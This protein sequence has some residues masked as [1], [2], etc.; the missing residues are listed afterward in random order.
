[1]A[2][3]KKIK[4]FS[5]GVYD[6][7]ITNLSDDITRF[8][9]ECSIKIQGIYAQQTIDLKIKTVTDGHE[10]II[11]T[12]K[13]SL[14]EETRTIGPFK[15]DRK[16]KLSIGGK[17]IGHWNHWADC[18]IESIM[19]Y[20]ES[21]MKT[22]RIGVFFDGTGCNAY[23]SLKHQASFSSGLQFRQS[24][25]ASIGDC[26]I[27]KAYFYNKETSKVSCTTNIWKL[28]Q[29]F[30]EGQIDS[31]IYQVKTYVEGSGTKAGETDS[32]FTMATGWSAPLTTQT[33]VIAKTDDAVQQIKN[34]LAGLD[35][36]FERVELCLFGFSR[37]ATSA[38]HFA[39][40]V[41]NQDRNLLAVFDTQK[42]GVPEI[43][44]IGLFDSVA[45]ILALSQW[46]VDVGDSKTGDVNIALDDATAA[47][48]FHITA[49]HEARE[50]YSLNH[51]TPNYAKELQL[52]GVHAD[53]GGFYHDMLQEK[54]YLTQILY[55]SSWSKMRIED[56]S[57]Y[58][59]TS[60]ARD[61]LLSHAR[62]GKIFQICDVNVS[63][64]VLDRPFLSTLY[65]NA[66]QLKRD[67]VYNGLERV[68]F[69]AM[70]HYCEQIGLSFTKLPDEPVEMIPDDLQDLHQ[71]AVQEV[72]RILNGQEA[73]SL[74]DALPPE[75][76]AKYIHNSSF[77]D[78][79][80]T[81]W[82]VSDHGIIDEVTFNLLLTNRPHDSYSRREYHADGTVF[83]PGK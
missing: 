81:S 49:A 75:V 76:A 32:V 31:R 1:M 3:L 6:A 72:D 73:R 26:V 48:I 2:K 19:S 68:S 67:A 65:A 60:A 45:S 17:V 10:D 9:T 7:E 35:A 69:Q 12:Q 41:E 25:Y 46:D 83:L 71:K 15:I 28:Y 22:L 51:V 63:S 38:R 8:Y 29:S 77:W 74:A 44:F 53:I 43:R 82:V 66:V 57:S 42:Y 33:G 56:T 18:K 14:G 24:L 59:L 23:N 62:W 11:F 47:D 79:M 5:A 61:K 27:P 70:R 39:N 55:S 13:F 40:R 64:D 80:P 50:N 16:C 58:K 21:A 54:L 30:Q 78:E 37:G 52:P 4:E 36:D 20:D 34:L